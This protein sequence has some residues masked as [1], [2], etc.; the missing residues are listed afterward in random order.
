[1]QPWSL[2]DEMN[3]PAPPAA[4]THTPAGDTST[5]ATF[6]S[7]D[8]DS[9]T[10]D[11]LP[12]GPE[13]LPKGVYHF[14][15][16]SFEKRS[17]ENGPNFN[18]TFT[19]QQEPETGRKTFDTVPYVTAEQVTAAQDPSNPDNAKA[20]KTLKD[21]LWKLNQL[22]KAAHYSSPGGF[23]P[24]TFF[25]SNPEVFIDL[26]VEEK[27]DKDDAGKYTKPTGTFRNKVKKYLPL[28]A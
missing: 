4:A 27:M 10:L 2:A 6:T 1:M 25:G 18:I 12:D 15:L 13:P 28:T 21:R 16:E 22:R 3:L 23:N 11:A 17:N 19:C 26:D 9:E 24:E 7:A 14:R 8:I 20:R 5:N